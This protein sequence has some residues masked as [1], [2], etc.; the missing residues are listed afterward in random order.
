MAEQFSDIFKQVKSVMESYVPPFVVRKETD[1]RYELWT[2]KEVFAA[3][4]TRDEMMLAAIM[5]EKNSVAFHYFPLY[6][7]PELKEKLPSDLLK[8][9]KGK[10]CFHLKKPDTKLYKQ[11]DEALKIGHAA[12]KKQGWI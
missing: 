10:T 9:L 1:K 8:V 6:C 3:G 7:F 11:I 5:I 12:F 4:K 2:G